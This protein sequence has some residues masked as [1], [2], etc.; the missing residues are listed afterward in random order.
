[1]I[2]NCSELY[3]FLPYYKNIVIAYSLTMPGNNKHPCNN[4]MPLFVFWLP[5][6][7]LAPFHNQC[8]AAY[9]NGSIFSPWVSLL[10]TYLA[11]LSF[12]LH[13]HLSIFATT[14][15]SHRLLYATAFIQRELPFFPLTAW[16]SSCTKMPRYLTKNEAF[17]Q[18]TVAESLSICYVTRILTEQ[19][20]IRMWRRVWAGVWE[21]SL[22]WMGHS[23]LL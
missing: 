9:C 20:P 5:M 10:N 22:G 7:L 3:G 16:K 8:L 18:V 11:F 4:C 1:M 19:H 21:G 14:G 2:L 23:S 15:K 13:Y 12:S 17:W 6:I